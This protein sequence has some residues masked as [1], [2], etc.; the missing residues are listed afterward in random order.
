LIEFIDLFGSIRIERHVFIG[1]CCTYKLTKG[2]AVMIEI[3]DFKK[4]YRF[5]N[6][7]V[8]VLNGVDLVVNKSDFISIIGPSKSGK[9]TLL[10][11]IGC[12]NE[13]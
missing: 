1:K 2:A 4:N 11:I 3:Q 7:A 6:I 5:G 10:P 13:N 8:P 9:T 12:K